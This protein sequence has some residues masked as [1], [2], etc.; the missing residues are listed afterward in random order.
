MFGL[1]RSRQ[2]L[3]DAIHCGAKLFA[4]CFNCAAA[5]GTVAAAIGSMSIE[6]MLHKNFLVSELTLAPLRMFQCACRQLPSVMSE[7]NLPNLFVP[8]TR[9]SCLPSL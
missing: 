3:F 1:F 4:F 8:V 6:L 5:A 2:S 9:K 7:S